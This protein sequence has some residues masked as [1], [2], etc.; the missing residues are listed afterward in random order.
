MDYFIRSCQHEIKSNIIDDLV[1]ATLN[2]P[3]Q[4]KSINH[5][6]LLLKHVQYLAQNPHPHYIHHHDDIFHDHSH[7]MPHFLYPHSF[8]SNHR[9]PSNFNLHDYAATSP[10]YFDSQLRVMYPHAVD[11]IVAESPPDF[12][13]EKVIE[14]H[15][16]LMNIL[17]GHKVVERNVKNYTMTFSPLRK[18]I[19][20]RSL[21]DMLTVNKWSTTVPTALPTVSILPLHPVLLSGEDRWLAGCLMHCI[22][23]KTHSLDRN[24]FPTLDGLVDLYTSGTNDQVYFLF[25]LRAV[26]KCLKWISF[27]HRVHKGKY[28]HKSETCEISFDVFDCISDSI[29]FYCNS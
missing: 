2:D 25:T 20:K 18:R 29:A 5:H 22:F 6:D 15:E 13:K 21:L 26:N 4:F 9:I 8:H 14:A 1:Y 12:K 10:G 27:K 24:G 17:S 19:M 11:D 16:E 7:D 3:H 23:Q 28:P